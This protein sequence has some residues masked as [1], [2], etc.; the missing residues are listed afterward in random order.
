[1][2]D[3]PG[4]LGLRAALATYPRHTM[5]DEDYDFPP[6]RASAAVSI[7]GPTG[8]RRR[9]PIRYRR[10]LAATVS[11]LVLI[12]SGL[13][14]VAYK[15]L[16]V[17]LPHGAPVPA[18]V[19]G[20]KDLDGKDQNILLIGNDTR[21]GATKAELKALSTENDGGSVNADTM[22]VLHVPSSGAQPTMISFP[23]D[24]WVDIP[25]YGM[26]K[27]N[28]AYPKA[29]AKAKQSGASETAAESAGINLT[30]R[31]ISGLTGLHIDHY[32]QVNLLGFYRISDAIGGVPVCLL[33]AQNA[34]TDS[35]Q[36]GSGYSGINLP[37]GRSVIKGS[38]ALAFVRQRHGL[39]N[40]DLDR[41]R[42]QQY[43][44]SAAFHKVASAGV[45]LNPFK[46]HRLMGAVSRS[47]LVDPDLDIMTFA[48]QMADVTSGAL[49]SVTIPNAGPQVIYPDGTETAI[50][51]VNTAALPDFIR[52]LLGRPVEDRLA[53]V[54][55]AAPSPVT[56]DVLNGTGVAGL[57]T[58]N[59]QAL[60]RR[61][62]QT[63]SVDSTGATDTTVVE[64][65]PGQ[66]A[67]AKAVAAAVPHVKVVVTSTV[68]RVTLVLGTDNYQVAGQ[69]GAN[70]AGRAPSGSDREQPGRLI[71][72]CGALERSGCPRRLH[73]LSRRTAVKRHLSRA[74]ETQLTAGN[75]P[76]VSDSSYRGPQ[77]RGELPPELDPRR[78][79][80]GRRRAMNPSSGGVIAVRRTALVLGAVLSM[81]IVG[82]SAWMWWT[83][84]DLNS[85]LTQVNLY[86]S[87]GASKPKKDI[88]GKDQN[89]LIIGNDDRS[90]ATDAEL[91]ELGTTRDGG[92]LNTDTMMIVHVPAN[93][94]KASLISLPRDSW[95]S[96]PG[97]G[98]GKLNSAYPDAFNAT[99]GSHTD[100]EQAG[101]RLLVQTISN[102][103]G[104]TVDHVAQV[105]LLGFY[106]IS[107][108]IGPIT[109]NMCAA[110]KEAN[111]GI[112]LKQGKQTIVGTQALAFVRQRYGFPNGLGDL[113][114]VQRQRY[115]LTAAFRRIASAGTL[116][117]PTKLSNLVSAV[118]RSL[119]VDDQLKLITLA[120]QMENLN[121]NNISGQT[122]PTQG[123]GTEDG[124]SVVL[125]DPAAVKTFVTK[126]I[127]STNA[128]PKPT[129]TVAP[130]SVTVNVF[131]AGSGVN[132]AAHNAASALQSAGFNVGTV[133]DGQNLQATTIRY[134]AGQASQAATVA[135]YV[136]GAQ[137]E[138]SS[139]VSTVTLYL[140]G[141]GLTVKAPTG[142]TSPAGG[143]STPAPTTGSSA[144]PL[145]A[146]CIY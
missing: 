23:R 39:P 92:S 108:A 74:G 77:R 69:H 121:A 24:S 46:L 80:S 133:S 79:R 21:D 22:I 35:D 129:P 68:Q 134:P 78:P 25:G 85:G 38:Q 15:K 10:L 81:V 112:N 82:A 119:T 113:D 2:A 135:A 141:D 87:G 100:K 117:N 48:R 61:G 111:S 123:F 105:D 27:L 96:V 37:A 88:D 107:K 19:A 1:M 57:A 33:H 97:Y 73:Q 12:G 130:S 86:G 84:R 122:I 125:V 146:G 131:N 138:Q 45:L 44:L 72:D 47:L 4:R 6:A 118:K 143:A 128:K 62:F 120:Q 70:D 99:A 63:G 145:D 104:L 34:R 90:T 60:Q 142:A 103:T 101:T 139:D 17:S 54:T 29:W 59:A 115:F 140:G 98:K 66:E 49:K 31:T 132:S 53:K 8:G 9:G 56:V 136:P 137:L 67:A 14:W 20:Q 83:Y 93:G 102:L 55:A 13:A 65:A 95:V 76:C 43:F 28:A 26:N 3:A 126:V 64:Y 114:R 109:V 71:A 116:L 124:Q 30:I 89:I 94:K 7:G 144:S 41:I 18:L 106:R 16:T 36:Y 75:V 58:Q 42:R 40:G 51:A 32:V 91:K 127:G 50:V 52:T 11:F 110:V 5:A